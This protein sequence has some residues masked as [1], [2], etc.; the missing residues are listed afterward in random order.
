MPKAYV[1]AGE[2]IPDLNRLEQ[3]DFLLL[4]K[5]S[6]LYSLEKRNLINPCQRD[7]CLRE[8]AEVHTGAENMHQA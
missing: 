6:I 7:R 4:L 3:A 8:I 2:P 1:Y 5:K